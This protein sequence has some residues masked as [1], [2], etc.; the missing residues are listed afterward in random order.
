MMLL[1][2]DK[3]KDLAEPTTEELKLQYELIKSEVGIITDKLLNNDHARVLKEKTKILDE[4]LQN[5]KE[6]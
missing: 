4:L 1:F 2:K 5:T 6:A 3:G